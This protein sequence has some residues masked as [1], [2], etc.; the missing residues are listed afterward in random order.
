MN[1]EK[2]KKITCILIVLVLIVGV[3]VIINELYR[4]NRGYITIWGAPEVLSYYG[5]ILAAGGGA[6]GVFFTVRYSQKQYREDARQQIMPFISTDFSI[7]RSCFRSFEQKINKNHGTPNAG[8]DHFVIRYTAKN[9][10]QYPYYL[11]EEETELLLRNGN[12]RIEDKQTGAII[13]SFKLVC[14]VPCILK[15]VGNGV[16]LKT[17]FGLYKLKEGKYTEDIDNRVTSKPLVLDKGEQ[18]Y[19]GMF[20]DL[21]DPTALG[22]YNFDIMYSDMNCTRYRRSITI[23]FKQNPTTKVVEYQKIDTATYEIYSKKEKECNE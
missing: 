4:Q 23:E 21:D 7:D 14:F 5:T 20:F 12:Q 13:E 22:T 10:V 11:S 3:P 8:H 15:N 18:I 2:W 9:G 16:S 19:V 6:V 17:T 1:K